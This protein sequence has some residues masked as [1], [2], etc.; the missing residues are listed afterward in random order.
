MSYQFLKKGAK[1]PAVGVMQKL[2]NRTGASLTVDGDYGPATKAAVQAFQRQRG[3][4]ADGRIGRITY[5]RLL[6]GEH[7]LKIVDLV[8]IFDPKLGDREVRDVLKVG[9]IAIPISG[10]SN[11]V[12]QAVD[13]IVAAVPSRSVF[14]LRIHGHGQ[15]GSG[16]ISQG[17]GGIGGEHGS[18][19]NVNNWDYVM[20]LIMRLKPI[21]SP[22]GCIQFMHCSTGSGVEGYQLL[23][24]IAVHLGVPVS[25]AYQIQYGGGASTFAYEGPTRTQVP[26]F[27]SLSAWCQTL[28]N[29]IGRSVP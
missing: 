4:F 14:I 9:G 12:E 10:M 29:F 6:A 27:G 25:A 13:D 28:P 16:G 11:G 20:P 15:A 19:I 26:I 3:L 1:L 21:F 23:L 5:P 7:N 2:L 18:S 24:D 17:R 8:D 22:Y